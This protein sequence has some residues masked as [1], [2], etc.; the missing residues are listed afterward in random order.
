M[1]LATYIA[2]AAITV[3]YA[4]SSWAVTVAYGISAIQPAADRDPTHLYFAVS[5][6]LV[7]SAWTEVMNLLLI[8]SIF[9]SILALHNAAS[10]YFFAIGREGLIWRSLAVTH[11]RHQSPYRAGLLQTAIAGVAIIGAA[12]TRL[13]PFAVVFS[14]GSAIGAVGM[15]TLQILVALSVIVFFRRTKLDTRLWNTL[16]APAASLAGLVCCLYLVVVNMAL[17]SG[18][19]SPLITFGIPALVVVAGAAGITSALRLK[20]TDPK[21]YAELG[22]SVA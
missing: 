18:S 12:V 15:L 7:G 22:R 6:R 10:R 17:M 5:D 21:G 4:L 20:K 1:P 19:D 16:L 13:D 11:P 9:A 8:T 2:V 14:Y 3:V